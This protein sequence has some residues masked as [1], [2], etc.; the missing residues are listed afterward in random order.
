[1]LDEVLVIRPLAEWAR[2]DHPLHRRIPQF[3]ARD[4]TLPDLTTRVAALLGADNLPYAA[5][6][7]ARLPV[8]R[9]AF[10]REGASVLEIL[11]SAAAQSENRLSWQYDD[12]QGPGPFSLYLQ[13]PT[14]ENY[15]V[16]WHLRA[17]K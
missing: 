6:P 17:T 5:S 16:S 10:Q 12:Q 13:T 1:M 9:W 3:E 15:R 2:R 4:V 11:N 14:N 8:G 7:G